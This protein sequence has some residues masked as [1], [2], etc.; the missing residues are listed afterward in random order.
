MDTGLRVLGL[1]L[2]W[3]LCNCP[4]DAQG[5]PL[6]LCKMS[7]NGLGN[8]ACDLPLLE[9]SKNW[10]TWVVFKLCPGK[11]SGSEEAPPRPLWGKLRRRG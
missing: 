10:V 1:W 3:E 9:T 4:R 8:S 7:I 2:K 6:L 11:S 5:V